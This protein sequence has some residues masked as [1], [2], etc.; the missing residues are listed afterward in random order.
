MLI[1]NYSYINQICGHNHSGITNPIWII[2]P[3]AMRGYFGPQTAEN[4]DSIKKDSLTTGT[5]PPYCY[6]MG[7]KGGLLSATVSVYGSNGFQNLNL[8]GGLNGVSTLDG[9]GDLAGQL[10]ALAFLITSISGSNTLTADIQGLVSI[11]ATLAA[12]GDLT[13]TL[14]ALVDIAAALDGSGDLSGSLAGALAAVAA[15][16][17]SGD[18]SASI[19]AAVDIAASLS[20][21]G[22]LAG[23]I[24]GSWSMVAAMSGSGT[25]SANIN[26]LAFMLSELDGDGTISLSS[27]AVPGSMECNITVTGTGLTTANV[28]QAVFDYLIEGGYSAADVLRLLSAVAAGKT[29][30]IDLGGG[31]ATVTF[32]DINDTEDR[33]VADMNNSERDSVTLDLN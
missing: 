20:G 15:V 3:H 27:G 29:T 17:G 24:T 18:L 6:V 22:D 12:S 23:A 2:S 32:R 30:I 16:S 13:G 1:A 19:Q 31:L 7:D 4:I 28:G 14:N 25:L 26:A 21:S 8:A 5:Y 9:A 11:A 33:V 10:G